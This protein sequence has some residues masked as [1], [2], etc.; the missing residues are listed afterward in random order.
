MSDDKQR[1][2]DQDCERISVHEA[3]ELGDW[4]QNLQSTPERIQEE[5][6]A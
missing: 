3:Y 5:A 4:T 6:Q 2:S 1:R